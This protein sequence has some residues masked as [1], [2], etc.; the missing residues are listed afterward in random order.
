MEEQDTGRSLDTHRPLC[1]CKCADRSSGPSPGVSGA[2]CQRPGL[3]AL[4]AIQT[5]ANPRQGSCGNFVATRARRRGSSRC[6]RLWAWGVC[7]SKLSRKSQGLKLLL[8][9]EPWA[10][11]QKEGRRGQR[12]GCSVSVTRGW[13]P[14]L[15]GRKG[16]VAFKAP[17]GFPPSAPSS[18]RSH[19]LQLLSP[20]CS[21]WALLPRVPSR[22]CARTGCMPLDMDAGRHG[23][24]RRGLHWAAVG[25]SLPGSRLGIP[26]G[27][28]GEL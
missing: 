21:S 13:K 24:E 22:V 27:H 8:K 4:S 17:R 7:S 1:R 9:S 3:V 20:C 19:F 28:L 14:A 11:K 10:R 23:S 6:I 16:W 15:P 18:R 25:G 26:K 2:V 12:S 5:R